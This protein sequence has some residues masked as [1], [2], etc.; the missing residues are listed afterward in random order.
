MD[1]KGIRLVAAAGLLL[2]LAACEKEISENLSGGKKVEIFLSVDIAGYNAGGDV[3]RNA[4]VREPDSRTIYLNDEMYLRATL[5]ADSED[6]LRLNAPFISGQRICFMAFNASTQALIDSKIYSYS[7]SASKFI[8]D[9]EPLG[10]DPDGITVYRFVAYSYFGESGA[11]LSAT[12]ID[13]VHDLVYGK[14]ATDQTITDTETSRTVT[15]HMTHQFARVK[16]K[17]KSSI[18]GADITVLSGVKVDGGQLA[19][20]TPF[21]GN[22]GWN[23]TATQTVDP[24]T[25]KS[26]TERESGYRTVKPV[27]TAPVTVTIGSVRVSVNATTFS[28]K[29]ASF[30]S[31]LD[32]ATSYTLVL[33]LRQGV[34]FAY[35]NV[36]WDGA[37]MTFDVTDEGHQGYQGLFFKWGSLV[38]ISPVGNWSNSSTPTYNAGSSTASTYSNFNSIPYWDNATYGGVID[39]THTSALVGDICKYIDFRYRL[40]KDGEIPLPLNNGWTD[41]WTEVVVFEAVT[42]TDHDGTYDFIANNK[43]CAKNAKLNVILPASGYRTLY[44]QYTLK[45][46]D[47]GEYALYW[48]STSGGSTNAHPAIGFNSTGVSSSGGSYQREYHH[49]VRCVRN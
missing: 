46:I 40:P 2:L 36:Y 9:G 39:N 47:V 15:I 7:T 25:V 35:S 1:R 8:P 16:V 24:F 37:K 27:G 34:A 6:E 20:L 48:G 49:S 19:T 4:D 11:T 12:S 31:T 22:I 3:V 28:D 17:V 33:D 14:T 30:G 18:P 38:G 43:G 41:G 42:T 13:P 23:G 32:V 29:W 5:E 45:L 21:S 26:G 44:D 10:V